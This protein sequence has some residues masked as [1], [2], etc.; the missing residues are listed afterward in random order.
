MNN[1]MGL[2]LRL[3]VLPLVILGILIIAAWQTLAIFCE[4]VDLWATRLLN[5]VL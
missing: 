1:L 4:W 3:S 5:R 2:L